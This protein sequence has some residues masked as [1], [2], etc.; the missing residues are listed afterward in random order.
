MQR[1]AHRVSKATR[2][3]MR[4]L[5]TTDLLR[6][7]TAELR[8]GDSVEAPSAMAIN[9]DPV[10]AADGSYT[11]KANGRERLLAADRT[12]TVRRRKA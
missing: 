11:V 3:R 8:K 5:A 2:Q 12:W 4:E 9:A 7:T 10:P 6:I 1:D